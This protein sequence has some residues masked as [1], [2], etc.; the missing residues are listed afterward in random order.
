MPDDVAASRRRVIDEFFYANDGKAFARVADTVARLLETPAGAVGDGGWL[1]YAGRL[2]A[3]QAGWREMIR[4]LVLLVGGARVH[5]RLRA[6]LRPERMTPA[7]RF[8][9]EDV[10]EV[11]WRLAKVHGEFR[12]VV[13]ETMH[14]LDAAVPVRGPL[15]SI[16]LAPSPVAV[17]LTP[18]RA[19]RV[20][21]RHPAGTA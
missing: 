18:P 1:R 11:V 15:S 3:A 6:L 20:G 5:E 2:V 21:M 9:V 10:Q 16:R 8:G 4:H 17:E 13:A 14:G 19:S 7:K 12:K